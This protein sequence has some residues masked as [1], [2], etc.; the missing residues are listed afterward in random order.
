MYYVFAGYN[1][2]PCGG[3]NDFQG[4]YDSIADA[5]AFLLDTKYDWW[6]IVLDEV[7]CYEGCSR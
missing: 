6:H 3:W 4:K 5:K 1:Y 2:Y 7:I